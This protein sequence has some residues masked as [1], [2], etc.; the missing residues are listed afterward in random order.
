MA[1]QLSSASSEPEPS[2]D[3]ALWALGA[4]AFDDQFKLDA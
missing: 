3:D 4:T 1:A 2:A